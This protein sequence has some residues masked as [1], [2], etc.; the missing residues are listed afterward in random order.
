M[1]DCGLKTGYE[2]ASRPQQNEENAKDK[3]ISSFTETT[4]EANKM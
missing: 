1:A 3:V 2:R 4:G